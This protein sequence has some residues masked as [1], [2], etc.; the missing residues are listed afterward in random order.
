M[1]RNSEKCGIDF[2]LSFFLGYNYLKYF[3]FFKNV[4]GPKV[5]NF[6]PP[7]LIFPITLLV[8]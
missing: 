7:R 8:T 1:G 6:L 5:E 3:I 4:I 2:P